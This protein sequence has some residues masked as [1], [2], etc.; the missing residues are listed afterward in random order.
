[1]DD[2]ITLSS[3]SE[4]DDSDVEIVGSYS[5]VMTKDDPLPLTSVR[6]DVDA[7]NVNVPTVSKHSTLRSTVTVET[8]A[9]YRKMS[10]QLTCS[11]AGDLHREK[12]PKTSLYE[13][14]VQPA[15]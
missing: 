12:R 10:L 5:H 9:D 1:M 2:V 7:V 11:F 8:S 4:K 13:L 6:V 14:Q 15:H 3:D